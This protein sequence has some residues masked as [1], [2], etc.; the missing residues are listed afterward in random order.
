MKRRI[1]A[2]QKEF[3]LKELSFLKSQGVSWNKEEIEDLYEVVDVKKG[4]SMQV[5]LWIGA[6]LV[7]L[8]ILS[9]VA[10]NW[11]EISPLSKFIMIFFGTAG[12]YTAG[13]LTENTVEKTSKSLYYIGGF[14]FGSGIFLVGQTFHLGGELYPAFLVWALGILPLAY[15][16]KDKRILS[17][18]VLLLFVYNAEIVFNGVYPFWLLLFIPVVYW[19][20]HTLMNRAQSVFLLNTALSLFFTHTSLWYFGL[21]QLWIALILFASG[22]FLSRIKWKGYEK[23]AAFVSV[24]LQC[25]YGIMLTFSYVWMDVFS[26]SVSSVASILFAVLYGLYLLFLLKEDAVWA[27]ILLCI[28]ILRFYTDYSYDFLPKSLFFIVGGSI[29][30]LFGFWFERKRRGAVDDE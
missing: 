5:I 28:L 4:N 26:E 11:S 3:L 18:I 24:V 19:I 14:L 21:D 6:V 23:P 13:R 25:I 30:I 10:S 20:N 17:F 12:F 9:S 1:T 27:I 2:S 22:L 15:Y 29:L 16:L 7:G 8:G